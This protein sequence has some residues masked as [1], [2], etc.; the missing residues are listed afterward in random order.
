M[1]VGELHWPRGMT[2]YVDM[3]GV[4]ADFEAGYHR[5]FGR[6]PGAESGDDPNIAKLVGTNFFGTLPKYDSADALIQLVLDHAGRYSICTAPLRGDG[7]NSGHWKREW[8]AQHIS[9]VPQQVKVNGQK[10]VYAVGADGVPNV[11]IDDKPKNIQR[12][13]AA[14]GIGIEYL[15]SR[16]GLDVVAQGLRQAS[17]W[18]P[19]TV[20][21]SATGDLEK[22]LRDPLGYSAIDHM[23][24][25]ISRRHKITP[26]RLHDLFVSKHGCTPDDWI[27]KGVA[28][29]LRVDVPNEGWLQGKIDYAQ[30]KGRNSWGVPYMGT[31]TAYTTENVPVSVD[32]LKRL[33]GQRGEQT[34]VRKQDLAAIVKIMKDTGQVPLDDRGREYAPYVTVAYNGEAWV[35]EGNHRIMA[36]AALGWPEL[37]VQISYFD[38]G[39]RVKSGAMYPGRIGLGDIKENFADGRGPGR[40]G[41]SRRH[42]IKK[43]VTLAQLDRIVHSKTASPRKKQ[44]AHWQANMRRGKAKK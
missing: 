14:G 8:L 27:R 5:L 9:P 4:L 25:T 29:G 37:P 12:W 19:A 39:E 44:L 24:Q 38:G 20:Q 26:E 32:I 34:N 33:P 15:A 28:E 23:M 1:K 42:G 43:G 11:L 6:R 35:R 2:V 41:D 36:A 13:R 30:D 21:E 7:K 31:T 40:P 16:D 10:E 3:D 18:R 22:D 17:Q